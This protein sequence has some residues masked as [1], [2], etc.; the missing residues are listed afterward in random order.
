MKNKIQMFVL[1]LLAAMVMSTTTQAMTT[2]PLLEGKQ[3]SI[4][5]DLASKLQIREGE[6]VDI[7]IDDYRYTSVPAQ[8]WCNIRQRGATNYNYN[9]GAD[10]L[11]RSLYEIC[12]CKNYG[13]SWSLR[14]SSMT[15]ASGE[16]IKI[17]SGTITY[18]ENMA[19]YQEDG[20]SQQLSI[21]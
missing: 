15:G 6:F 9:C 10:F 5:V 19:T 1:L 16:L 2:V 20:C 13:S 18:D 14:Y 11:L 21:K 3:V 17:A 7:N 8:N 4:Y 12:R